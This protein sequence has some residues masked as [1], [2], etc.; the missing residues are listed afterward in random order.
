MKM[1]LPWMR[2]ELWIV[3]ARGVQSRCYLSYNFNTM[4]FARMCKSFWCASFSGFVKPFLSDIHDLIL[5]FRV[6]QG[7]AVC[8]NWVPDDWVIVYNAVN[9]IGPKHHFAA[10]KPKFLDFDGFLV[11]C[12]SAFTGHDRI[13][14]IFLCFFLGQEIR[15]FVL[16]VVHSDN[17]R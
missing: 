12:E 16:D 11:S 1:S 9:D 4:E 17:E 14:H 13:R 7:F 8:P 15:V 2:T 6:R 3:R 10:H 5:K